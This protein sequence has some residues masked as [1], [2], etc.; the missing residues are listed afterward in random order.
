MSKI[1]VIKTGGKQYLV[2]TGQVLR[3]EKLPGEPKAKIIFDEVL[4]TADG[5]EAK[6]GQPLVAGVKVE[7]EIL[8]QGLGKKLYVETY[9]AK[10]RKHRKIG[11]RQMFTEVKIIKV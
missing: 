7:A 8:K 11:H 4:M 6:V 2:K 1:A 10:T 5:T 9:R 3:V